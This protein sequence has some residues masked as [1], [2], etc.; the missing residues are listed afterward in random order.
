[1]DEELPT[2]VIPSGK[3]HCGTPILICVGCIGPLID[4]DRGV[5]QGSSATQ[6]CNAMSG[7]EHPMI[8]SLRSVPADANT[9]TSV[10]PQ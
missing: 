1:M 9:L 5:R 4:T 2:S 3:D 8:A 7:S 6:G 10:G